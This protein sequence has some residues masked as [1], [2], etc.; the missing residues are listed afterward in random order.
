MIITKRIIEEIDN[1]G[2]TLTLTM[3]L[4]IDES[5]LLSLLLDIDTLYGSKI[6]N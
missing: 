6:K 1:G 3:K 5:K 2:I 4:I